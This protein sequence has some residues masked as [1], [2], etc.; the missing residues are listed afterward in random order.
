MDRQTPI[1]LS[2]DSPMES[3][4]PNR[5]PR[6]EPVALVD[7]NNFYCSCE[8]VFNP[9]L[10]GKPL[11]VLSNNDGMPISRSEEA[12]AVGIDMARP[13]FELKDIIAK[14]DVQVFSS[15]YTLYGDFSRR[16]M[17]TIRQFS[18]KVEE[19][20]IDEAF[21]GLQGFAHRNLTEYGREMK[22]TIYQWTG[23]PVSVGI[24]P[25][26][27]MAK[28]ASKIAKKS[29]KSKGVLDLTNPRFQEIALKRYDVADI[30]KCGPARSR[31]LKSHSIN[32]AW[33]LRNVSLAWV[34]KK[35]GVE[36]TR[37]VKELRGE[38]CIPLE[39]MAPKKKR[40][41]CG[42]SF[43]R[44]VESLFEIKECLASHIADAAVR[45][46]RDGQAATGMKIYLQTNPYSNGPQYNKGIG[47]ELPLATDETG[48]LIRW[49]TK[50]VEQIY[51]PGIVYKRVHVDFDGLVPNNQIQQSLFIQKDRQKQVQLMAAL[52]Q[53]NRNFGMGRLRYLAEGL[54]KAWKTRF[55]YRSPRYTTRW[56]E[57]L[58][59]RA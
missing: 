32:T 44:K 40:I 14:Y 2:P 33:D 52:D 9:K 59:V 46:R 50:A 25:T 43:G 31:L 41:G 54:E 1:A 21:V 45:L 13:I 8:R 4:Q 7:C 22:A 19:Y 57:L 16:V 26:K 38:P 55:E 37:M 11:I 23:I 18:P 20:S 42:R 3:E 48:E 24:A 28:I 5:Q 53:V 35:M 34:D 47:V 6:V 36:G 12:K 10:T 17:Q 51:K 49:A 27:T 30:W 15:N 58:T 29:P 56:D 39:L